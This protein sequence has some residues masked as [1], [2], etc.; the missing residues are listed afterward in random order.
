[1][2]FLGLLLTLALLLPAT[3]HAQKWTCLDDTLDDRDDQLCGDTDHFAIDPTPFEPWG[4]SAAAALGDR[5]SGAL[6][7][8]IP[9]DRWTREVGTPAFVYALPGRSGGR[10]LHAR[11]ERDGRPVPGATVT[12]SAR[13]RRDGPTRLV[14]L[15]V[16]DA[17]G[18][19]TLALPPS[20]TALRLVLS[21]GAILEGDTPGAWREPEMNHA[22]HDNPV[23]VGQPGAMQNVMAARA[24]GAGD[25]GGGCLRP[26]DLRTGEPGDVCV[27]E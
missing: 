3:A 5:T 27:G 22:A 20:D 21:G 8:T 14:A 2:R 15:G 19:V 4:E 10:L 12:A 18:V 23:F 11:V 9:T 24:A 13:D 1:M 16:A 26:I 25:T 6:S 17:S 7:G